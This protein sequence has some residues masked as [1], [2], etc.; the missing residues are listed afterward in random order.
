MVPTLKK[1]NFNTF[2]IVICRYCFWKTG[3]RK[4][5]GIDG[6]MTKRTSTNGVVARNRYTRAIG[7]IGYPRLYV[8]QTLLVTHNVVI[9][10]LF[11]APH[12]SASIL[13]APRR[14]AIEV[15]KV[16]PLAFLSTR[17]RHAISRIFLNSS[18]G[19]NSPNTI[20]RN[21]EICIGVCQFQSTRNDF[22][23]AHAKSNAIFQ[24]VML[25]V[26]LFSDLCKESSDNIFVNEE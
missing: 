26:M 12:E 3:N 14:Q 22:G 20:S 18:L 7:H 8:V 11:G 1:K 16:V 15:S 10:W 17:H 6:T 5:I 2:I 25:F 13:A 23:R 9:L 21:T 4:L 19:T 24:F